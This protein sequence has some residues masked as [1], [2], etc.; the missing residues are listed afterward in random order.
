MVL[1]PKKLVID[2]NIVFSFFKKE[3]ARRL[4]VEKLLDANCELI[5]PSYVLDELRSDKENIIKYSK[6][7]DSEFV[8]TL[9]EIGENIKP[10][11]LEEYE[12]FLS[13]ANKISPHE[14]D[15]PYFT[16]AMAFN[17]GIWSD[18]N[19]FKGQSVVKIFTT[20]E[21]IKELSNSM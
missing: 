6:I 16:L 4:L 9:F 5:S 8:F 7:S 20:K 14:K 21:L 1:L 13:E 19:A 11:P 2:A 12:Q 17:C 3:S 15:N 18:E 10:I